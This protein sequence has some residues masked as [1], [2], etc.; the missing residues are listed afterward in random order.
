MSLLAIINERLLSS[1]DKLSQKNE[2]KFIDLYKEL[3]DFYPDLLP[4]HE[5]SVH[6]EI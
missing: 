2:K 6:A 1:T 5:D 4:K 3:I